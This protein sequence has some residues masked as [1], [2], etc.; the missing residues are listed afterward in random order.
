[1]LFKPI[2]CCE[3]TYEEL[4]PPIERKKVLDFLLLRAYL[5]GI[6]TIYV[7][8]WK[9]LPERC[10]PTY[11]ELKQKMTVS[12]LQQLLLRCEPTYEELKPRFHI[13]MWL[14]LWSCEPT[15]EELK[16][17]PEDM[18]F[19]QWFELRAYLWG[20]ETVFYFCFL[21]I[22]FGVASLPMRNWNMLAIRQA[23]F[24]SKLRAYLWGIETWILYVEAYAI[25]SL[26]AYLWG[27]ETFKRGCCRIVWFYVASL[28]M[29]NWN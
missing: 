1:M 6:E 5:W 28:P 23:F 16:Q 20:I 19:K 11:E 25:I 27:I 21:L 29:R 3:P 22:G 4:K 2:D 18:E 13:W 26:R 9:V 7:H 8:P 10:E 17:T 14:V 15:Y 12:E 24:C